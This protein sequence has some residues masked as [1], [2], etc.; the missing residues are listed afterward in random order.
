MGS[1]VS[2]QLFSPVPAVVF[3]RETSGSGWLRMPGIV[4]AYCTALT[5]C[6]ASAQI[7]HVQELKDIA[8]YQVNLLSVSYLAEQSFQLG[9]LVSTGSRKASTP[10]HQHPR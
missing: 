6:P 9:R 7:Y 8:T 2:F 3:I 1:R 4:L 5:L 10:R